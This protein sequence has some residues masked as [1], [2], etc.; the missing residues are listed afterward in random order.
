MQ[1]KKRKM[2]RPT[3]NPKKYAIHVRLDKECHEILTAY[4]EKHNVSKT[5]AVRLAIKNLN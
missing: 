3:D 2:G 5:E 4:S 1:N